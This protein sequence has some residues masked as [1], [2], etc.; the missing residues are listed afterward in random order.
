MQ[1]ET[2]GEV[3]SLEK[4]QIEGAQII[5]IPVEET[6]PSLVV[7]GWYVEPKEEKPIII[8]FNGNQGSFSEQY[9]RLKKMVKSGFGL[10]AFDY[11]GYPMSLGKVNEENI[12]NDSLAV[13]D[14][15]AAKQKPI[16][17]YGR[18]LGSAPATYVASK[19]EAQALILETPFLSAA[20]VA[21]QRYPFI[22]AGAML[23]DK[24]LSREWIKEVE[25]PLFIGH[26]TNDKIIP[27]EQA[28]KL[29]ALAK[30]GQ[31]LWIMEGGTHGNLWSKGMWEQVEIF[32]DSM[33]N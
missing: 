21:Q 32:L 23:K 14:W 7:R 33:Q 29:F 30:N 28:K 18:S 9:E 25:E 1:Y 20:D 15:A 31:K 5:S 26:G 4:A 13:F 19:R 8:Y 24:Y 17:L 6:A 3:I 2:N 11:R 22:P 27:V 16:I 10:L 12:L